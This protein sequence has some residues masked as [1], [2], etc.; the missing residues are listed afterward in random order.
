[1]YTIIIIYM[2]VCVNIVI[3][4]ILLKNIHINTEKYTQAETDV[5]I[6][7]RESA[8]RH[9]LNRKIETNR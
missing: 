2:L 6:I 9:M 5:N 7:Y 8:H 3:H 1:M 4:T